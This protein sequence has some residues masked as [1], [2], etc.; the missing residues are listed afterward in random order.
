MKPDWQ[1][2]TWTP[3]L[4]VR[5]HYTRLFQCGSVTETGSVGVYDEASDNVSVCVNTCMFMHAFVMC[6][7]A[8]QG[9]GWLSKIYVCVCACVCLCV[10]V[11]E[12]DRTFDRVCQCVWFTVSDETFDSVELHVLSWQERSRT[13]SLWKVNITVYIFY[14]PH[15]Y[16]YFSFSW[17][18]FLFFTHSEWTLKAVHCYF[19]LS[20]KTAC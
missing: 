1:R 9:L 10:S 5:N 15:V 7:P 12:G 4:T 11:G 20:C 13:L 2:S 6:G 8:W 18:D 3:W 19:W 16:G 14:S 17:I